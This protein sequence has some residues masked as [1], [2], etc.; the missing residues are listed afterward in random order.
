MSGQVVTTSHAQQVRALEEAAADGGGDSQ[1][2]VF[3]AVMFGCR[4][5]DKNLT[6]TE[7]PIVCETCIGTSLHVRMAKAKFGKNID[8][9]MWNVPCCAD[10]KRHHADKECKLCQRPFTVFRW[11]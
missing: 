8:V 4:C 5:A 9:S 3:G 11:R 1:G 2:K 10:K 7:F 6:A